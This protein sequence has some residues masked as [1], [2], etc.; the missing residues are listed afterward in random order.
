[1]SLGKNLKARGNVEQWLGTVEKA[2]QDSLKR[3][4]KSGFQSY[5]TQP[6]T[7]WVLQQPAQLV[8]VVSQVFWVQD[9]GECFASDDPVAALGEFFE[10]NV[11]NLK[12]LTALVRGQLSKLHRKILAALITIDVHARDIVEQVSSFLCHNDGREKSSWIHSREEFQENET[13]DAEPLL[14]TRRDV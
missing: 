11:T 1:M 8:L 3:Q 7:E 9:V 14:K 2:M 13:V 5:P 6:R 12:G 4:A 10:T